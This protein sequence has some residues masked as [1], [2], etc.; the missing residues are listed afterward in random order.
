[1]EQGEHKES[2]A[3]I[4]VPCEEVILQAEEHAD[5]LSPASQNSQNGIAW[6][7]EGHLA[8]VSAVKVAVPPTNDDEKMPTVPTILEAQDQQQIMEEDPE[9]EAALS[10][11]NLAACGGATSSHSSFLGDVENPNTPNDEAVAVQVL[12]EAAAAA[13]SSSQSTQNAGTEDAPARSHRNNPDDQAY[14]SPAAVEISRARPKRS[15]AGV[16][17]AAAAAKRRRASPSPPTHGRSA[18]RG[19]PLGPRLCAHQGCSEPAQLSTTRMRRYCETHMSTYGLFPEEGGNSPTANAAMA[20]SP[21]SDPQRKRSV[22]DALSAAGGG[23]SQQE[24]LAGMRRFSGEGRGSGNRGMIAN[25]LESVVRAAK[26]ANMAQ[27]DVAARHQQQQQIDAGTLQIL[28]QLQQQQQMAQ[29]QQDHQHQQLQQLHQQGMLTVLPDGSLAIIQQP[30][31]ASAARQPPLPP[32]APPQQQQ[33]LAMTADGQLV[34]IQQEV[35]QQLQQQQVSAPAA[36]APAVQ[37]H[38]QLQTVPQN[39]PLTVGEQL[40]QLQGL[41]Y[42]QEQPQQEG[43]QAALIQQQQ[44]E[45]Q[46]KALGGGQQLFLIQDPNGPPGQQQLVL[47]QG[48][49]P[50]QLLPQ[51]QQQQQAHVPIQATQKPVGTT[52]ASSVPASAPVVAGDMNQIR[53]SRVSTT[54]SGLQMR[55][56]GRDPVRIS[57]IGTSQQP[58]SGTA[59]S[60]QQP[61]P[62]AAAAA[63]AAAGPGVGGE[64]LGM[65]QAAAYAAEQQLKLLQAAVAEHSVK[66]RRDSKSGAEEAELQLEEQLIQQRRREEKEKEMKQESMIQ[67]L[68]LYQEELQQRLALQRRHQQQAAGSGTLPP[69]QLLQQQQQDEAEMRT[70]LLQH[71]QKLQ[72]REEESRVQRL[73]QEEQ[74]LRHQQVVRELLMHQELCHRQIQATL[75][76]EEQQHRQQQLALLEQ[77]FQVEAHKLVALQQAY[78]VRF[79]SEAAV[80]ASHYQR[81]A[82]AP[83]GNFSAPAGAQPQ[84]QQQHHGLALGSAVAAAGIL[85]VSN[86]AETAAPGIQEV[87]KACST[88]EPATNCTAAATVSQEVVKGRVMIETSTQEPT[89]SMAVNQEEPGPDSVMSV[90]QELSHGGIESAS[91]SS[92][93]RTPLTSHFHIMSAPDSTGLAST[94]TSLRTSRTHG[95]PSNAGS[96][97]L[98]TSLPTVTTAVAFAHPTQGGTPGAQQVPRGGSPPA[99]AA[100]AAA[101]AAP[102]P[103]IPTSSAATSS[104]PIDPASA[105]KEVSTGVV[106]QTSSQSV[107]TSAAAAKSETSADARVA[108]VGIATTSSADQE[109]AVDITE[110]LIQAAIA[111]QRQQ[112]EQETELKTLKE[113][114]DAH[115]KLEQDEGMP[116]QQA[117][118]KEASKAPDDSQGERPPPPNMGAPSQSIQIKSEPSKDTL[119]KAVENSSHQVGNLLQSLPIVN[120]QFD[121]NQRQDG[122]IQE[123]L[124]LLQ[125][126][127]VQRQ[128][129]QQQQW[130][131]HQ[132]QQWKDQQQQALEHAI[133]SQLEQQWREQ[134]QRAPPASNAA[135]SGNR[136]SSEGA[137][138]QDSKLKQGDVT[139]EMLMAKQQQLQHELQHGSG[140]LSDLQVLEKRQELERYQGF[141]IAAAAADSG[142]LELAKALVQR[143]E[144][145]VEQLDQERQMLLRLQQQQ[146]QQQQMTSTAGAQQQRQ[147]VLQ[148]SPQDL[149]TLLQLQQQMGN[150]N[151]HALLSAGGGSLIQLPGGGLI[152]LQQQVMPSQQQQQQQVMLMGRHPSSNGF[153][154]SG[155]TRALATGAGAAGLQTLQHLPVQLAPGSAAAAAASAVPAAGV[156]NE[157]GGQ[158]VNV[159]GGGGMVQLDAALL[160]QLTASTA[161]QQQLTGSNTLSVN[162][163]QMSGGGG[164]GQQQYLLVMD[165]SGG[166]IQ[167][168]V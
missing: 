61:L 154:G 112:E 93:L 17:A 13:A 48:G 30:A 49:I 54:G 141:I 121:Q 139:L 158:L 8:H 114:T 60:V 42:H 135:T 57:D 152:Q 161:S 159:G 12:A 41:R 128:Q 105:V 117:V 9:E 70:Q 62:A 133:L 124:L 15:N 65:Q 129:Q 73:E 16:S 136:Q 52:N 134:Q 153:G 94:G 6:S 107:P 78:A 102:S 68:L 137:Q 125:S 145:R 149:Q 77:I 32:Q 24:G 110:L 104:L 98:Q 36:L 23:H 43:L 122:G 95:T 140:R 22:K 76:K 37:Q 142:N 108:D 25:A 167:L 58:G 28:L 143:M 82:V 162:A 51:Q 79:G 31:A 118:H 156:H 96:A 100:A 109:A 18:K 33:L 148:L 84:Q 123:Q 160:Q 29:Q 85:P 144:T 27:Q 138:N 113:D 163:A 99:A 63:C 4:Q 35:P 11:C 81:Q 71:L 165:G 155:T 87:A 38:Q 89:R 44:Q 46:Q 88:E 90:K 26:N 21:F 166:L 67:E 126:A 53:A 40:A 34:I 164:N 45:Q 72:A 120:P 130:Q 3:C 151:N 150:S 7:V 111:K 91:T 56:G 83:N 47:L 168:A 127:L 14:Y 132:Q 131:D 69:E 50:H 80:A 86:P 119:G 103:T 55:A 92:P 115:P 101:A 97:V 39:R 20:G 66:R 157:R 106:H 59:V 19:P 146:Q 2:P 5:S 74:I 147:Q 1:M 10:L 116:K 64:V 75:S